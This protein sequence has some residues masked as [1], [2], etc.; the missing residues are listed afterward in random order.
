MILTR[1]KG[2][3]VSPAVVLAVTKIVNIKQLFEFILDGY[4]FAGN[5]GMIENIQ[6]DSMIM[7]AREDVVMVKNDALER[8][9]SA[10][11]TEHDTKSIP[12]GLHIRVKVPLKGMFVLSCTLK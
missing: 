3:I 2:G 12:K 1:V 4:D 6:D 9:I 11:I 7:I 8:V 10:F 5:Y